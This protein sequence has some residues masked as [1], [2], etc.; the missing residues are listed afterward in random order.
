MRRRFALVLIFASSISSSARADVIEFGAAYRC[1]K[2]VAEFEL[3]GLVEHNGEVTVATARPGR[4]NR[5]RHGTHTL[6][7]K[8]GGVDVI[9]TV[10]IHPATNGECM[11]AG[12]VAL[13]RLQ[14]GKWSKAF[15]GGAGEPFNWSCPSSGMPMLTRLAV[16][17]VASEILL[18]RCTASDWTW[19]TGYTD[20]VCETRTLKRGL[21]LLQGLPVL[22]DARPEGR[23]SCRT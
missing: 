2:A 13:S 6:R 17:R 9:A 19:D 3:A 14:V 10:H 23:H 20:V 18:E 7:C 11:G 5:L 22:A 1:D 12:Y 15:P 8:V 16:K 4:A 21:T